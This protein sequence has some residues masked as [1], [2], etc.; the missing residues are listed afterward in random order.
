ML[1]IDDEIVDPTKKVRRTLSSEASTEANATRKK[2]GK[3]GGIGPRSI[4]EKFSI[5]KEALNMMH[6]VHG[7]YLGEILTTAQTICQNNQKGTVKPNILDLSLRLTNKRMGPK[8]NLHLCP[9][10]GAAST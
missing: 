5:N 9:I 1:Q 7:A 3:T 8:W 4:V 6:E 2:K 10:E